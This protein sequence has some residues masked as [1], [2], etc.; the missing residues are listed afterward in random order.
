MLSGNA[1]DYGKQQLWQKWREV[2]RKFFKQGDQKQIG[3]RWT[4]K[5]EEMKHNESASPYQ[6][7]VNREMEELFSRE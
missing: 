3:R 5:T 6:G 7:S 1:T 4:N 2:T